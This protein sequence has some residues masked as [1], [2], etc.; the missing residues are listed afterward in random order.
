M[1]GSA[2]SAQGADPLGEATAATVTGVIDEDERWRPTVLERVQ[3]T[4]HRYPA[5]GPFLV[6]ALLVTAFSLIAPDRFL[7]PGNLSLIISQVSVVGTL[8]I[9]QTIIILTAGVDLSVGAIAVF[10]SIIM[11]NLNV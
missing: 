7:R 8:A 3:R 11:A 1:T 10:A 9:G 6:L 5:L 2:G 4:L